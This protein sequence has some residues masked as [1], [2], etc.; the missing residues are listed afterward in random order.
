MSR[1][2]THLT[3]NSYYGYLTQENVEAVAARLRKTF[4]NRPLVT[5]RASP[6][7][8]NGIPQVNTGCRLTEPIIVLTYDD[9]RRTALT[10]SC[11]WSHM[12][13]AGPRD[14]HHARDLDD[15]DRTRIAFD[16]E[17]FTASVQAPGGLDHYVFTPESSNQG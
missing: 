10:F 11:G 14:Q 1:D 2:L 8:N 12:F 13:D 7:R 15:Q 9:G 4:G 17:T 3:R 5:V 16:G 6:D